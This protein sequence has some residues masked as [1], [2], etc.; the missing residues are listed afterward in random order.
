MEKEAVSESL[1]IFNENSLFSTYL[2]VEGKV[3]IYGIIIM[4]MLVLM[5]VVERK[6]H[7]T[8]LKRIVRVHEELQRI[9]LHI[10]KAWG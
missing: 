4:L 5:N 10:T 7:E 8:I 2:R 1:R 3:F 6:N 9:S